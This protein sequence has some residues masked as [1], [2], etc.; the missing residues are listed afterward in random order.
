MPRCVDCRV[1]V[2]SSRDCEHVDVGQ[3]GVQVSASVG[4][5]IGSNRD[6]SRTESCS[7]AATDMYVSVVD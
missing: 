4:A 1:C 3:V 6:G 2:G 7:S 5:E